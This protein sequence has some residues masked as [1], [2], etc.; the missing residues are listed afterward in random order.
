MSNKPYPIPKAILESIDHYKH[1]EHPTDGERVTQLLID[2]HHY[3]HS[4]G[5]QLDDHM[6]AAKVHFEY[7][8]KEHNEKE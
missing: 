6:R 3:C 8:R 2:L 7:D 1:A 5:I 4:K